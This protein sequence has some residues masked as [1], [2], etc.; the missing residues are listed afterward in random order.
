MKQILGLALLAGVAAS[1]PSHAGTH[2][3]AGTV[4]LTNQ[5]VGGC[6]VAS[7]TIK[8]KFSHFMGEPTVRMALKWTA[9]PG[10]SNNCLRSGPTLTLGGKYRYQFDGTVP[11]AGRGFGISAT[12]SPNWARMFCGEDGSCLGKAAAKSFYKAGF[13]VGAQYPNLLDGKPCDA[14]KRKA[15]INKVMPYAYLSQKIYRCPITK[16]RCYT[17]GWKRSDR[18]VDLLKTG[19][20]VKA[21]GFN[22]AV[23]E[24]NGK[25]VLVFEGTT[26]KSD[27]FNNIKQWAGAKSKQY[28][29]AVRVARKA[30][31]KYPNLIITG[32]SLGGG[33]ARE[34]A[35]VTGSEAITFNAA[36]GKLGTVPSGAAHLTNI[37]HDGEVLDN[38]RKNGVLRPQTGPVCKITP[39]CKLRKNGK[40]K[41]QIDL[42]SMKETIRSLRSARY[43]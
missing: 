39:R 5:K 33:L 22:A 41:S 9:G 1:A 8:Y 32:H 13:K 3:T 31:A 38:L 25:H 28:D 42:H 29:L 35:L 26:S 30:K 12:G 20:N 15:L 18:W 24:K 23:F 14:W 6:N 4:T 19:K 21:E 7:M 16:K 43:R 27:W 34:A 10:T 36:T 37:V 40:C 2:G 17:R 11:R